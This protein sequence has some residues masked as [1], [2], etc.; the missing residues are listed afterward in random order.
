MSSIPPP[1]PDSSQFGYTGNSAAATVEITPAPLGRRFGAL[2]IDLSLAAM[3][4]VSLVVLVV[5]LFINLGNAWGNV[6]DPENFNEGSTIDLG[7]LLQIFVIVGG[8]WLLAS[9][10]S[11]AQG[12]TPG[13]RVFGLCVVS[14][15]TGQVVGFGRMVLR[16]AVG[17]GLIGSLLSGF[18]IAIGLIMILVTPKRQ[19]Y[20]DFMAGTVVVQRG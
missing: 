17:K 12:T 9:I 5:N 4:I 3:A 10:V 11:W 7:V 15:T 19:G 16:E 1:P 6:N 2:V 13:K 14:A 8:I 20:W 18:P